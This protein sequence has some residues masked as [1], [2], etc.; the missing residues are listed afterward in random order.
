MSEHSGP[1]TSYTPEDTA[2]KRRRLWE[3]PKPVAPVEE[4]QPPA[5]VEE[6]KPRRK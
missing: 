2:E 6:A 4:P 5:K 1:D 3:T